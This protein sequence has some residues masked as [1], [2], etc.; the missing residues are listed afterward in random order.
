MKPDNLSGTRPNLSDDTLT[1]IGQTPPPFK[2]VCP[3]VRCDPR[4]RRSKKTTVCAR[5]TSQPATSGGQDGGR[6]C[7]I[8]SHYADTTRRDNQ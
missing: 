4:K 5:L 8:V 3:V 7:A 6:Y 2:G 1:D